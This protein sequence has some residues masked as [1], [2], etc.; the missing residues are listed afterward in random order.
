LQENLDTLDVA[1]LV[2]G[3]SE[4]DSRYLIEKLYNMTMNQSYSAA[5]KELVVKEME[6]KLNEVLF[7]LKTYWMNEM[8][9]QNTELNTER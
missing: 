4:L 2:Q 6:A 8:S 3:L 5:Q 1:N 9:I 7:V